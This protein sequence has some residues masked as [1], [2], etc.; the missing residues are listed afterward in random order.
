MSEIIKTG[1]KVVRNYKKWLSSAFNSNA[2]VIY[3]SGK[4]TVPNETV[5][6]ITGKVL[7]DGPLGVFKDWESLIKF[8]ATYYEVRDGRMTLMYDVCIGRLEVWECLYVEQST[9]KYFHYFYKSAGFL[10]KRKM[11]AGCQEP[12]GTVFAKKVMVTRRV[13]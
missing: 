11:T 8:M 13:L 7:M 10:R 4:W 5:E 9:D 1:Y 6:E 12:E 2:R 3:K